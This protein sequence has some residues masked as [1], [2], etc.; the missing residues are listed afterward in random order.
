MPFALTFLPEGLRTGEVGELRDLE[1]LRVRGLMTDSARRRR[2]V[3]F[4]GDVFTGEMGSAGMMSRPG[5]FF[6]ACVWASRCSEAMA[7]VGR[8]TKAYVYPREIRSG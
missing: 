3:P 5:S 6:C 2:R 7:G 8:G 1:R 4:F